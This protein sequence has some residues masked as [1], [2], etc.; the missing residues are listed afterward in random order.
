MRRNVSVSKTKS[1]TLCSEIIF[2]HA[3]STGTLWT[4]RVVNFEMKQW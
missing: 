3:Q 1:G 4:E 2:F